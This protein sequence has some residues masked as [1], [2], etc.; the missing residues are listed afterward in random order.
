MFTQIFIFMFLMLVLYY[1]VTIAIDLYNAKLAEDAAANEKD[2]EEIDISREAADFTPVEVVRDE[3]KQ[4]RHSE[5]A[6]SRE[7]DGISEHTVPPTESLK[8]ETIEKSVLNE[9]TDTILHTVGLIPEEVFGNQ[10]GLRKQMVE[11][12]GIEASALVRNMEQMVKEGKSDMG[13]V[14]FYVEQRA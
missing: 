12:D 3:K 4:P 8:R 5:T 10:S 14:I 1:A 13:D 7:V 9:D 6:E 2:E 11:D